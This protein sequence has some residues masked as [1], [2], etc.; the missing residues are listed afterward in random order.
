MKR[1][2]GRAFI[3]M[4][5]V[6]ACRRE[7]SEYC[8]TK[9][10]RRLSRP[11]GWGARPFRILWLRTAAR[12]NFRSTIGCTRKRGR[13]VRMDVT[14]VSV[15]SWPSDLRFFVR[16]VRSDNGRTHGP[17]A[18]ES[19]SRAG[20]PEGDGMTRPPLRRTQRKRVM[21]RRVTLVLVGA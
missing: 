7:Q 4:P 9:C 6:I 2:F 8:L 16:R 13:S 15:A 12:D 3:P 11:S 5:V 19:T 14:R 20:A 21:R 17:S 1:C 10:R 18:A